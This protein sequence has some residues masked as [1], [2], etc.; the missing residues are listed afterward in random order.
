M[1]YYA[2]PD[3]DL[4]QAAVAVASAT[5]DPNYPAANLI[6]WNPAKPAKLTGTSGDWVVQLAGPQEVA[7]VAI[8]YHYL[9]AGLDVRIQGNTSDSWGTPAFS[10]AITIPAK[11]L[12]G[13]SYQRWTVT[14]YLIF[15]T[16]QTYQYWR[17]AIVG[18]NSQPVAVGR[19]ML[20]GAIR[21]VSLRFDGS[22]IEEA[23]GPPDGFIQNTT[24]L[25][26]EL[27]IVIGGPR[28]AMSAMLIASDL[29]AS[30]MNVA[31]ATEYMQL[32]QSL[33]GGDSLAGSVLPFLLIPREDRNDAWLVR[34]E[35]QASSRSHKEGN[36][37]VWP[38]SVREVSRGLPWP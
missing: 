22:D 12:D 9:D 13:P 4:A 27:P 8:P 18:T 34:P 7:A 37:E 3:D 6:Q 29:Y 32:F 19:L 23:D 20:L 14:P 35:G 11:R 36:W 17:L 30:V 38:F 15:D 24:E 2:R 26:V 25:G 28:R 5:A 33:Y 16:P 21:D 31:D 10:H 1:G